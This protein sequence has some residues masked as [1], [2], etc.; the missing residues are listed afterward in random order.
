MPIATERLHHIPLPSTGDDMELSKIETVEKS[1]G[2]SDSD[3]EDEIVVPEQSSPLRL[4]PV[5]SDAIVERRV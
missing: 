5:S 1:R 2:K 4:T 3:D